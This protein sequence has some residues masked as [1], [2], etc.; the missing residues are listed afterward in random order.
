MPSHLRNYIKKQLPQ[1][2]KEKYTKETNKLTLPTIQ[3][4]NQIKKFINRHRTRCL[5]IKKDKN[6]NIIKYPDLGNHKF[7]KIKEKF[8]VLFTDV[9]YLIWNGKKHY[10]S[11]IID[12][13]TK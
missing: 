2:L 3:K 10:Q 13:Y 7:N 8:K 12:G 9:T 1:A 4:L 5:L 11:T 6:K